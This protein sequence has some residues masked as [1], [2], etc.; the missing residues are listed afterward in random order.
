MPFSIS[1]LLSSRETDIGQRAFIGKFLKKIRNIKVKT[2]KKH[3]NHLITIPN[4]LVK[5]KENWSRQS[6]VCMW[7]VY[8]RLFLMGKL[9]NSGSIICF[10]RQ[11]WYHNIPHLVMRW[12]LFNAKW[13]NFQLYH[14]KNKLY[15]IRW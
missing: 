10:L 11:T 8:K 5:Y 3:T 1:G 12:L 15:S 9:Y 14:G 6:R 2:I 4:N 7:C 13:A